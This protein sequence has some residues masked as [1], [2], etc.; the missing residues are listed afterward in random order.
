MRINYKYIL[1]VLLGAVLILNTSCD[2]FLDKSPDDRTELNTKAKVKDALLAAYPVGNYSI[3]CEL[4]A[5][6]FVDNNNYITLYEGGGQ[7]PKLSARYTIHDE[8]FAW[9]PAFSYVGQDSPSSVWMNLYYSIAVANHALEAIDKLESE[10]Y[11]QNLDPQRGEALMCRAYGHF[12]LVNIFSHAY[13]DDAV[14]GQDLGIPYV[15]KPET[16]VSIDYARGTVTDVYNKIEEDIEK[17]FKLITDEEYSVPKYHFN[18]KAAAAFA[19]RFYLYKRNYPKVVE[20]ANIVLG[21]NPPKTTFRDWSKSYVNSSTLGYDYIDAQ[22]AC[23]LLLLPVY[24]YFDDVFGS[25]YGNNGPGMK[26]SIYGTGPTWGNFPPSFEGKLYI[27][28]QQDYGVL[29]PKY[30]MMFEFTDKVAGTG[31]ARAIRAE[32]TTEETLLCRAEAYVYMNNIP[33]AL[34]DLQLWNALRLNSAELTESAIRSFYKSSQTLF[35]KQLNNERMSSSFVLNPEYKPFIDC[36][37]HFRRIETI[38]DGFRWF[39][40]KRYG[41]E[42][43]HAIG[44]EN[45]VLKLVYNDARRAIQIPQSVITAGM[46]PNPIPGLQKPSKEHELLDARYSEDNN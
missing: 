11:D 27:A 36:I 9:E 1:S 32:F 4:S 23:N 2:D 44:E 21:E 30:Y 42:I 17:G 18:R 12:I 35:V 31:F 7:S 10:G 29:F 14:S 38:Y 13:K 5:D 40:I 6:N 8:I 20:Y 33:S 46:T 34:K 39:D 19:A 43:E 22:H 15:T 45:N 25:R 24:T 37:L 41:I 3:L 28:G 26:G 16:K